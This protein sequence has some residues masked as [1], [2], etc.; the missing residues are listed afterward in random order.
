M[1]LGLGARSRAALIIFF[2]WHSRWALIN[3]LDFQGW[4]LFEVGAYSR[5]GAFSNK[6]GNSSPFCGKRSER[7]S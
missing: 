2:F 1:F 6:Y 5:V 7:E 3:F 4:R